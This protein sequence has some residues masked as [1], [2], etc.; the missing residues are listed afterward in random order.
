M[1]KHTFLVSE[2]KKW[3]ALYR[4]CA[5]VKWCFIYFLLIY[6]I[7]LLADNSHE[8]NAS[9][10]LLYLLELFVDKPHFSVT[11]HKEMFLNW[12]V[13]ECVYSYVCSCACMYEYYK[14][15]LKWGEGGFS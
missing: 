4:C 5:P 14:P 8:I 11:L 10:V 15:S 1:G 7:T 12:L 2:E 9:G 6:L 3:E 13:C